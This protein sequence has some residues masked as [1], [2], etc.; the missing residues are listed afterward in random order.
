MKGMRLSMLLH[1]KIS[2]VRFFVRVTVC[3]IF[4]FLSIMRSTNAFLSADT[5]ENPGSGLQNT[6][7]SIGCTLRLSDAEELVM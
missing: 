1:N 4:P 3:N 6:V 5:I 2:Y 7:P